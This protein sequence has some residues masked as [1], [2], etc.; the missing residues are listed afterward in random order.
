M[1]L[2]SNLDGQPSTA[3]EHNDTDKFRI[4]EIEAALPAALKF[5]STT[6]E[7]T[8]RPWLVMLLWMLV[9]WRPLVKGFWSETIELAFIG[10]NGENV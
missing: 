10:K 3:H 7:P 8:K 9:M 2:A 1:S 4:G 6:I 5:V